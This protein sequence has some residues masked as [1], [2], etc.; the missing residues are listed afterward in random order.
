MK[1]KEES[2]CSLAI[3]DWIDRFVRG[4]DSISFCEEDGGFIVSVNTHRVQNN[5][6][7][8][9]FRE[10]IMEAINSNPL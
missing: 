5:Y 8:K 1:T 9:N 6:V 7:G 3:C 2:A 10:A 4:D